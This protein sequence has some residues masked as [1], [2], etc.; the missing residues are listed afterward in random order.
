MP[1]RIR[2]LDGRYLELITARVRAL[3]D[4]SGYTHGE[5]AA[6]VGMTQATLS[7]LLKGRTVLTL[8]RMEQIADACGYDVDIT[9]TPKESRPARVLA[10]ENSSPSVP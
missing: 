7:R 2:S 9:F 5:I 8:G 10:E 3:I 6:R 1:I 4:A